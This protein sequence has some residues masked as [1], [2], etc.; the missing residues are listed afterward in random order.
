MIEIKTLAS[1]SSGNA[2]HISDEQTE[3]LIECGINFRDIQIA[4]DFQTRDIAGCLIS[5]EHKDHTKGLKDVLKAGIDVYASAG[6]IES[7]NITHH[8]LKPIQAKKQFEI[9]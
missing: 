5:H 8:R 6:T 2:Y 9:G 7:E 3:L 1:G 4:L